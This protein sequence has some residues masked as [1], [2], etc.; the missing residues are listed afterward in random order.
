M[1]AFRSLKVLI[2][3]CFGFTLDDGY[4]KYIQDFKEKWTIL[5][6]KFGLSVSNKAHIVFAHL[7]DV[8]DKRQ[9]ALG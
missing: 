1:D 4:K 8:L 6:K 3:C 9:E 2:D 7:A 5:R